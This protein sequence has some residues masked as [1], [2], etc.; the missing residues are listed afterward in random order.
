MILIQAERSDIRLTCLPLLHFTVTSSCA[1]DST[2]RRASFVEYVVTANCGDSQLSP[3][4]KSVIERAND[5]TGR[6]TSDQGQE[7]EDRGNCGEKASH[8]VQTTTD[9]R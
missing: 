9:C 8:F 3:A 2:V 5:E 6:F 1:A 7:C 4:K